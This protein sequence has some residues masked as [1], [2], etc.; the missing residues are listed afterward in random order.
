MPQ[1]HSLPIQ[2]QFNCSKSMIITFIDDYRQYIL[3]CTH[4]HTHTHTNT[5]PFSSMQW[6]TK[7]DLSDSYST[8]KY[9][10]LKRYWFHAFNDDSMDVLTATGTGTIIVCTVLEPTAETEIQRNASHSIVFTKR[11]YVSH[12]D[13][14]GCS[15]VSQLMHE[16]AISCFCI[17]NP[18][19]K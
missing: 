3:A 11:G 6:Q 17:W 18:S 5:H 14:I 16:I 12:L 15:C 9:V 1:N 13:A 4:T 8:R 2:F 10:K 7:I 19:I